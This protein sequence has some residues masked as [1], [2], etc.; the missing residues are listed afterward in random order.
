MSRLYGS[1]ALIFLLAMGPVLLAEPG[2]ETRE[3]ALRF[4]ATQHEI[5]AILIEEGQFDRVLPEFQKILDLGFTGELEQLVVKE[6]WVV[7]NELSGANQFELGHQVVSSALRQLSEDESRFQL[8]MLK[9]K[10]YK[11]Q[12]LVQE[13]V[14]TYRQAQGVRQ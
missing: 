1:I 11:Q 3:G 7:V 12:G 6:V 10:L 13:A 9:G 5:I 8:L 2:T 4:A 14:R